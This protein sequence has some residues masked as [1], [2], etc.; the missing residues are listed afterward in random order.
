MGAHHADRNNF[1]PSPCMQ[2]SM[3]GQAASVSNASD[4]SRSSWHGPPKMIRQTRPSWRQ[5]GLTW[6]TGQH[7]RLGVANPLPQVGGN[8]GMR[9]TS[10][11]S[12]GLNHQ[13]CDPS[14][15]GPRPVCNHHHA[16][17]GAQACARSHE[18]VGPQ[19]AP[20]RCG[21]AQLLARQAWLTIGPPMRY[22]AALMLAILA[23]A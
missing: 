14:R 1:R 7:P 19:F 8:K 13:G 15:P 2:K 20:K 18:S 22:S 5:E 9:R 21:R 12:A 6:T 10:C 17:A 16:M 11:A 23:N 3:Q 4:S